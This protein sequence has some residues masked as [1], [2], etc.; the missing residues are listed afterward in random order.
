ML[1]VKN[2]LADK[3]D[4]DTLIF[5]EVDSGVGGLTLNKVAERME[6]LTLTVKEAAAV[7]GI[8]LPI[9]STIT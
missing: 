6:K 9:S 4:I 3:D 1:A 2:V 7:L 5:D 8:S